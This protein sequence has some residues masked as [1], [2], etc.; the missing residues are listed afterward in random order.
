MLAHPQPLQ[1]TE[2]LR[3]SRNTGAP[4]GS[5]RWLF[6]VGVLLI[7]AL[8]ATAGAA[9]TYY[10]ERYDVDLAVQP[11]G[12]LIVTETVVFAFEGGPFTYVFR[13]LAY[14]QIDEIDRLQ[15]SMDGQALPQGNGPG[16]VEIVAG[17]PLKVTWHFGPT[18]DATHTFGLIYR[19]QGAIRQMDN[20]DVLIWRAIPEEHD[21]EIASSTITLSYPE[22]AQLLSEP[23]ALGADATVRSNDGRVVITTQ[24]LEEDQDVI[25]E[26]RFAPGSLVSAPP[27]WQ[28]TQVERGLQTGKALPWGAAGA[29]LTALAGGGL[30]AWFWRRHPRPSP[31]PSARLM[32]R[33]EPPATMPPAIGVKLA[34]G[35]TPALATLFDLAYRGVLRIEEAPGRWGRKFILQRQPT[36]ESLQLHEEGLL[37]AL[38]RSKTG[39]EFSLDISETG[40]RLGSRS[41]QFSE[42]LD[43]EMITAGFLDE[44]RRGQRQRLIGATVMAMLLGGAGFFVC[45]IWGAVLANNRAWDPL[46]IAA[47]VAGIGAGLFAVGFVGVIVAASYSTLTAEGEQ[48]AA[49]WQSFRDY[50][51]DVAKGREALVRSDLSDA[52]LPYAAGFGLAKR[53]AQRFQEQSG[54]AIPVWFSALHTDNSAAAF[55]A[56][57]SATHSSF[58]SG[59]GGAAGAAGASGGG[60]SGAG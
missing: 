52:Y 28:V 57:M 50:L 38:F 8:P 34:G 53:W 2:R 23:V 4:E 51:K 5:F 15:A 10:A 14:R 30:L 16:Q 29:A 7:L 55:V 49:G 37:D 13:D 59:A 31:P 32:Q 33:T 46:P 40:Q 6:L 44:Q 26:A 45:L 20:A 60:A 25:V 3:Q 17:D 41:K 54:V 21:Y 19:V 35:P 42:P 47:L 18:S 1:A 43:E 22:G 24:A 12:S 48:L 9:K 36:A 56:V 11:D 39:L 58:G 27:Q